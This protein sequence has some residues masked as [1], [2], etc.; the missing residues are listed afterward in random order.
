MD[1][2]KEEEPDGE[3]I[4]E[5]KVNPGDLLEQIADETPCDNTECEKA[6]E[7]ESLLLS[8][9]RQSLREKRCAQKTCEDETQEHRW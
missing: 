5:P 7:E 8:G 4:V 2:V 9:V 6:T 3:Q 1:L